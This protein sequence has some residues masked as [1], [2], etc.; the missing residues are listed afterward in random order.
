M[1]SQPVQTLH[2]PETTKMENL[3]SADVFVATCKI[4]LLMFVE[5]DAMES[6]NSTA[7][8]KLRLLLK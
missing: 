4:T 7:A 2:H 3:M 6:C 8:E 5:A 1:I